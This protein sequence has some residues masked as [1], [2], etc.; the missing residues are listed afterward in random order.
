MATLMQDYRHGYCPSSGKSATRRR[1]G[2]VRRC[3]RCDRIVTVRMDKR[4][5]AH[6]PTQKTIVAL[7]NAGMLDRLVRR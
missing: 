5:P 2:T 6:W 7:R 4:W 1:A 3:P